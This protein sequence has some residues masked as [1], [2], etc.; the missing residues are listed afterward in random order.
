MRR[1]LMRD[2]TPLTLTLSPLAWGEGNVNP[3]SPRFTGR[4]MG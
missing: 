2:Y 1:V 4:G 3:P